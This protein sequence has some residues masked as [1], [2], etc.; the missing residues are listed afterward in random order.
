MPLSWTGITK[1]K[2]LTNSE[3]KKAVD[4]GYLDKN[5]QFAGTIPSENQKGVRKDEV[6][7]WINLDL[8]KSNYASKTNNQLITK[9]NVRRHCGQCSTYNITVSQSDLNLSLDNKIRFHYYSCTSTGSTMDYL[10]FENS[11]NFINYIC[12]QS[13]PTTDPYFE[14]NTNG[15]TITGNTLSSKLVEKPNNCQ[16]KAFR[17]VNCNTTQTYTIS[18]PGLTFIPT[19]FDINQTYGNIPITIS[20]NSYNTTNEVFIGNYNEKYGEMYTGFGV[21]YIQDV[22]GFTSSKSQTTV[23]VVVYS[24][25]TTGVFIPYDISITIGCPNNGGTLSCGTNVSTT[26]YVTYTSINVTTPGFIK[27][28]TGYGEVYQQLKSTGIHYINDCYI[29]ET[30]AAGTPYPNTAEYSILFSGHSCNGG[31]GGCVNITFNNTNATDAN[32]GYISCFNGLKIRTLKSNENFTVCGEQNSAYGDPNVSISYGDGVGCSNEQPTSL[33]LLYNDPNGEYYLPIWF[34][35]ILNN[36][37][38][39]GGITVACYYVPNIVDIF[40][41]PTY[42]FQDAEGKIPFYYDYVAIGTYGGVFPPRGYEY[43][44]FTGKVGTQNYICL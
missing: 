40:G 39:C 3:L 12:A 42:I 32:I 26:T 9:D 27:Y 36:N 18:S 1:N 17:P 31:V 21:T 37:N 19:R 41:A 14:I 38:V 43:N 8:T 29:Y 15:G 33:D 22:V 35:N 23:D 6:V 5:P 10:D 7:Q 4:D 28:N 44:K 30:L 34:T 16:P 2:I 13:C 24:S 20:Y 11:G 25:T